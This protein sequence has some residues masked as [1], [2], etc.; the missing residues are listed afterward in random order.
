MKKSY[1]TAMLTLTC[2]L[3]LGISAHAQ[4]TEGVRVNV[5]FKF[6]A[7]GATLP[8]GTYTV[9]R[10]SPV[11]SQIL[12]IRSL[13]NGAMFLPIVFDGAATGQ[14]KLDFEHVGDK[15]FLTGVETPA[16]VYTIG[17]PRAMVALA[18]TKDQGTVSSSGTK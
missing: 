13:H 5:P 9:A 7:G 10:I 6:A 3:G 11:T 14:A 1:L 8:A 18:Q 4:D 15:Y 16:G 2:L 17:P 12:S